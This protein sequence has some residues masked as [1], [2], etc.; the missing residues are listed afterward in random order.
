MAETGR[1]GWSTPSCHCENNGAADSGG[2][3]R[4]SRSIAE[5]FDRHVE[6]PAKVRAGLVLEPSLQGRASG[7]KGQFK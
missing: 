6:C 1:S 2:A 5:S 4:D 3:P 7:G